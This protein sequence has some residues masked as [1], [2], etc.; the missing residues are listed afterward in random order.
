MYNSIILKANFFR[1]ATFKF[2]NDP[3]VHIAHL[4][5]HH[6]KSLQFQTTHIILPGLLDCQGLVDNLQRKKLEIQ[7]CFNSN[8]D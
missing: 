7:V 2:F 1:Y 8:D 6:S 3:F 4:D 5:Q